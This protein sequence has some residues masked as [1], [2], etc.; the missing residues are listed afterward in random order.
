MGIER[1]G[2]QHVSADERWGTPSALF[3]MW[4]GAIW[5]VEYVVYGTLLVAIFGLSFAQAVPIIIIG[6]IASYLLSGTHKSP[7]TPG[8]HNGFH[9]Q[10]SVVRTEREPSAFSLQLDNTGRIRNRGYR[11]CRARGPGPRREG[12]R[13]R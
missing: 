5:N 2:I 11:S 1:R 13:C 12:Q 7:G 3:W 4:T 9:D 6:S 8:R 10:S